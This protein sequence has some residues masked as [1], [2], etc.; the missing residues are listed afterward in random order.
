MAEVL[1]HLIPNLWHSRRFA[2]GKIRGLVM[3]RLDRDLLVRKV[4]AAV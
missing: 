3:P 4:I 1:F 2:G